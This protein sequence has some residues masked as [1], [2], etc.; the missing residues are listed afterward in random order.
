MASSSKRGPG[1][2]GNLLHQLGLG[3]AL[4]PGAR[5]LLVIFGA[6][7][8]LGLIPPVEHFIVDQLLLRPGALPAKL[9][10]SLAT[11]ERTASRTASR[12]TGM[13]RASSS[14]SGKGLALAAMRVRHSKSRRDT[15]PDLTNRSDEIGE[16]SAAL[17]DMTESLWNRMDAIEAFAADVAHELRT[18]LTLLGLELERLPGEEGESLRLQVSRM[19]QLVRQLM[20]IAKLDALGSSAPTGEPVALGA[21]AMRVVAEMAPSVLAAQRVLELDDLGAATIP[22]EPEAL[23][24]ALRNLVENAVRVTPE[25]GRVVVIAGPGASLAVADGGPGL[26][27]DELERLADRHVRADHAS[28]AGAGLGLAIVTRIVAA[29]HGRLLADR[30]LRS[31]RMELTGISGPVS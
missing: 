11:S 12:S 16:L 28:S 18:P 21:L 31:I 7:Y 9:T 24:A 25:G 19:Q 22:G 2:R 26:S 10:R 17:R 29:H 3:T 30:A 15:I 13:T 1:G 6:T 23:A 20:L 5:L 4:T 8:L 27:Q 14:S